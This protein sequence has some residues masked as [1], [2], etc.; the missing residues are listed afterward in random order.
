MPYDLCPIHD[1]NGEVGI[2]I[3][4]NM[5]A[6]KTHTTQKRSKMAD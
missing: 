5:M 6:G 3:P 1:Q 4:H 2:D